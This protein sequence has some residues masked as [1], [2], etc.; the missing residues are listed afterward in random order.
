MRPDSS[1]CLWCAAT[2]SAGA[3]AAERPRDP[4]ARPAT[5]K[6]RSR[7]RSKGSGEV[8]LMRTW[9]SLRCCYPL[10]FH[11]LFKGVDIR[12]WKLIRFEEFWCKFFL[13]FYVLS[14]S[15]ML[16]EKQTKNYIQLFSQKSWTNSLY[17]LFNQKKIRLS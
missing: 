13:V 12:L 4:N 16:M 6:W 14:F 15:I 1:W 2:E 17:I 10:T 5:T 9:Y 11:L 3:V 8:G 7:S